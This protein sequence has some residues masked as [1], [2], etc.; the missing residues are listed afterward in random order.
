M[1]LTIHINFRKRKYFENTKVK[2][3]KVVLGADSKVLREKTLEPDLTA[4]HYVQT[5]KL[6]LFADVRLGQNIDL[7]N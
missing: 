6:G 5:P 1:K 3:R 4:G 7:N 2:V